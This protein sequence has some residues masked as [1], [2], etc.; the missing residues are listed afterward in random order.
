MNNTR[1]IQSLSHKIL[2]AEETLNKRRSA[3]EEAVNKAV[4]ELNVFKCPACGAKCTTAFDLPNIQEV[5]TYKIS[6][7]TCESCHRQYLV[8]AEKGPRFDDDRIYDRDAYS[9]K[10]QVQG[11]DFELTPVDQLTDEQLR[12]YY[13]F[14]RNIPLHARLQGQISKMNELSN[15]LVFRRS[16]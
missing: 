16:N 5:W 2:D 4:R 10:F 8:R 15:E 13:E 3:Y 11:F 7:A 9:F 12:N 1:H 14:L 6:N